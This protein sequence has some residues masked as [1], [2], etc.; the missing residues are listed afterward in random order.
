[1]K[2][3]KYI[4]KVLFWVIIA[5]I[6]ICAIILLSETGVYEQSRMGIIFK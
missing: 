5:Y 1:M 3:F 2:L 6:I 4:L